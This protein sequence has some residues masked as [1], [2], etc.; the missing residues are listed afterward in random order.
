MGIG[1]VGAADDFNK[2][3]EAIAIGIRAM[4]I[5]AGVDFLGQSETVAILVGQAIGGVEGVK[6]K[7]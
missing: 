3:G 4:R 6:A 7:A 5:G 1:G 2:V